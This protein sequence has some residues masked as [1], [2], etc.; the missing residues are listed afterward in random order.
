MRFAGKVSAQAMR[1]DNTTSS[2]PAERSASA[3][4]SRK[5]RYSYS[6]AP[7]SSDMTSAKWQVAGVRND[8]I[9]W[10]NGPLMTWS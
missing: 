4:C 9:D 3:D 1:G 8:R 10:I 6:G 2:V 5:F 7:V